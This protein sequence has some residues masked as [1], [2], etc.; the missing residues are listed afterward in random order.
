MENYAIS[1]YDLYSD[2][3]NRTGGEIYIG[4]LGPVRTG[5]STFIKR[6][7]EEMV[8][9]F[10]D[11]PKIGHRTNCLRAP[12]ARPSPLRSPSSFLTRQPA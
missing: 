8:L 6:F 12:G 2:I 5:K 1:T 4:V 7:M 3:K 10:M 11:M 9:P